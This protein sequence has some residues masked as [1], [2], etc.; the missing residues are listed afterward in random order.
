MHSIADCSEPNIPPLAGKGFDSDDE[1]GGSE[2][3]CSDTADLLYAEEPND[4]ST[5][6]H[7]TAVAKMAAT[8]KGTMSLDVAL[9][10]PIE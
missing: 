5:H 2:S 6:A 4:K 7:V 10:V 1:E 9:L 8:A 3:S